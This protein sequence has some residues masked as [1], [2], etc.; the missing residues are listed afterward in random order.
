MGSYLLEFEDVSCPHDP[1]RHGRESNKNAPDNV[2]LGQIRN[3]IPYSSRLVVSKIGPLFVSS[4]I[5]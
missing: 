3:I 2:E 5:N 1:V 4:S